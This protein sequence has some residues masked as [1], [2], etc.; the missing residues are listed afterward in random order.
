M[1]PM[2]MALP[3]AAGDL[4]ESFVTPNGIRMILIRAGS[5]TM[6]NARPTDAAQ[7]GQQGVV[8]TH[9]GEDERPVRR[10]TISQDFY[11][12]ETEILSSQFTKYQEDHESTG[13][14]F[15]SAS[16]I[17]WEDAAGFAD[18]M[19]RGETGRYQDETDKAR[20]AGPGAPAALRAVK[21]WVYRLPMEAEW[22]Y[23]ARAGSAGHFSSGAMPP[24]SGEPNVWGAKNM[25]TDAVEWVLDCRETH[26]YPSGKK[27]YEVTWA[28]G[29]RTGTETNWDEQGHVAWR[30][31]HHD[32][33]TTLWTQFRPDGS[34]HR[35]SMWRG[36]R[37]DGP[38]REWDA[39]GRLVAEH[40]FKSGEII[41]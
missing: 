28:D 22:E 7:L 11:L 39:T 23:V 13:H 4:P 9:G 34:K 27:E 19:S 35:E 20:T 32:D 16:G 2:M 1:L 31:E 38:A 25:H 21:G 33:G 37:C 8:F 30:R 14:F 17:S 24:A 36:L 6:G 41:R 18:W 40:E 12:S 15:P 29:R 10:V 5:F 3:M 26:W